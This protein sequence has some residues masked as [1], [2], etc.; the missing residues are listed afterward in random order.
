MSLLPV[1][2]GASRILKVTLKEMFLTPHGRRRRHRLEG[3]LKETAP[4][5]SSDLSHPRKGPGPFR[6]VPD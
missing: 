5:L 3:E 1:E 4:Q 2:D 6:G